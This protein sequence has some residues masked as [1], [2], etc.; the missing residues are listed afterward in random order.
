VDGTT[1]Q[2]NN[3]TGNG[4]MVIKMV[5]PRYA[6]GGLQNCCT[7]CR[8]EPIRGRGGGTMELRTAFEAQTTRMKKIAIKRSGWG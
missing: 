7:G 6:N 3:V 2:G 8:V 5:R 1:Y 4:R